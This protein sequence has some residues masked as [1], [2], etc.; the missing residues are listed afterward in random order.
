MSTTPVAESNYLPQMPSDVDNGNASVTT[1][2]V[3]SSSDSNDPLAELSELTA[4]YS[5]P[6]GEEKSDQ[7]RPLDHAHPVPT[8]FV[9]THSP[10]EC[11][12]HVP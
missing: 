5:S 8:I 6:E 9:E 3:G 2:A 11:S 4:I 7:V 12:I 1:L 10:D